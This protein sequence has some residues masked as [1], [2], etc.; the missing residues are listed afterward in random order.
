MACIKEDNALIFLIP[1]FTF[2]HIFGHKKDKLFR[3]VFVLR[4]VRPVAS[5][6]LCFICKVKGQI[7]YGNI[8]VKFHSSP[9]KRYSQNNILLCR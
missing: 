8:P 7:F 3:P 6:I 4:K 9:S 2:D 1:G 5:V